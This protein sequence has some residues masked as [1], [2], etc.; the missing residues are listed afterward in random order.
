[1]HG[2]G[3]RDHVR[4][5][6]CSSGHPQDKF[7]LVKGMVEDTLPTTRSE[8]ISLLRSDTDLHSSTYQEVM[9]SYPQLSVDGILI[10]DDYGGYQAT[11]RATDQYIDENQLP[12]FLT[13]INPSVRLAVKSLP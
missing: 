6:V 13:R 11:K 9:H 12:L 3:T 1:M 5:V 7:V 4:S 8:A 2:H 10:Q